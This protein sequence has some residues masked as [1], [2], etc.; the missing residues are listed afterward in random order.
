MRTFFT[1]LAILF[2]CSSAAQEH[3]MID[4]LAAKSDV[5]A[6]AKLREPQIWF[7]SELIM[8][9]GHSSALVERTL[10]GKEQPSKITVQVVRHIDIENFALEPPQIPIQAKNFPVT[11]ASPHKF[12]KSDAST[13]LDNADKVIVFLHRTKDGELSA[14]DGFLYTLPYSA[15]LESA[16]LSA[17]K[18]QAQQDGAS[19]GE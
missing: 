8:M 9:T 5:I 6:V 7:T 12:V 4:Q 14:V 15:E 13:D 16:V 18:N 10:K 17:A 2:G 11:P 1:I 3:P 19:N